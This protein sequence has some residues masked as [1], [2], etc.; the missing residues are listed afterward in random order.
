MAIIPLTT[1]NFENIRLE[2]HPTRSFSSSS[3]PVGTGSISGSVYVFAERSTFNKEVTKLAAFNDSAYDADSLEA[4]RMSVF[5]SSSLTGTVSSSFTEYLS[6]VNSTAESAREKKKVEVL[7]FTPTN[8]FTSDTLRKNVIRDALFPFYKSW[9]PS[10][11]WAYTNYHCFNFFTGANVP[12]SSCLIYPGTNAAA[13]AGA[14]NFYNPTGSFTFA[15]YI[16]PSRTVKN[17]GGDFKAG[18]ILQMSSSY[19]ISL[20]TGSHIDQNGFPDR[21]RIML[22][23]SHSADYNPTPVDLSIANNTRTYPQDLIFLSDDNSLEFNKWQHVAI[24][25]DPNNNDRSGSFYIDGKEQENSK[26][27]VNSS[28]INTSNL[29]NLNPVF[30]GNFYDGPFSTAEGFFNNNAAAAEGVYDGGGVEAEPSG[31][32][33][34]HPLNAEIHDLRIYQNYLPIGTLLTASIEGPD[35]NL[36]NLLFYVPPFFTKES[37][38]RNV[39][40]TPFQASSRTTAEPYNVELAF[41]VR[42]RDIN[43]QNFCREFVQSN[44]PRLLFL[45]SSTIN[46]STQTYTANQFLWESA[47]FAPQVRAR[48]LLV[49]PCDNGKFSPNYNLLKSGTITD[50]PSPGSET[51][52]FINDLGNLDLTLISLNNMISTASIFGGLTQQNADGTDDTSNSGI[53]QEILGTSPESPGVSPGGGYTILQRTRDNSSNEI[54][55]FD[56]SNLFYGMK[57]NPGTFFLKDSKITGSNGQVSIIIRDDSRGNLYRADALSEHAEWNSVGTILYEEGIAVITSPNIPMFGKGQF[58][59]SFEGFQNLHALEINVPAAAGAINSSSNLSYSTDMLPSNYANSTDQEF[60]IIS[61]ILFHD[62]NLN[63]ITKTT[64]SQPIVKKQCDKYL[65]RVKIDF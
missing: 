26:F 24:C 64:M 54:V 49:M 29:G 10:T 52:R 13:G 7:R 11:N 19:A 60:S 1:D 23:L 55:V 59:V 20:I 35:T 27:I 22:Q 48:N 31:G 47:S 30:V 38:T 8:T 5:L 2:L 9:Y 14:P 12:T 17:V 16:N 15:F 62:D 45:T 34:Q 25:W 58:E 43:L 4:F 57:I 53:L 51:D 33:L 63:V 18:T 46:E 32:Y 50:P 42:G 6:M 21:F 40:I 39:L 37:P 65:F 36:T 28:S 61:G 44:Y 56:A 3:L 41:G